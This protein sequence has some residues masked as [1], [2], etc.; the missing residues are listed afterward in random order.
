MEEKHYGPV[1]FIPGKNKGRYPYCHSIYIEG[2]G[3]LI[4]P[5]SDRKRLL[6]LREGPGVRQVWLSHWH[7]DHIM[8]LDLFDDLPLCISAL[9]A[10][11]L[12][13]LE[14][15]LDAYGLGDEAFRDYWRPILV[16]EFNFHPR[17]PSVAF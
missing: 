6:E 3:I 4:D 16:D 9:D 7:E 2:T 15:F 14:L 5:A 1:W 8:H 10:A 17:K 11:P 12:S 13:D